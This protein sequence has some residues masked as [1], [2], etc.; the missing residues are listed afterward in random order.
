[1]DQFRQV[2][3]A[4]NIDY[5]FDSKQMLIICP[6]NQ[7]RQ[8]KIA[9]VISPSSGL[10]GYVTLARFGIELDCLWNGAIELASPLIVQNSQVPGTNGNWY[11]FNFEH[12]LDSQ[13]PQ[14]AWF[15]HL[16]CAPF[17]STADQ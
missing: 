2:C 8:G 10:V 9:V 3:E 17:Q 14:G 7:G 5:Y 1:M 4:G 6:K 11:P 16:S 15:S 12:S 13:K